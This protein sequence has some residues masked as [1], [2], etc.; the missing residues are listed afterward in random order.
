MLVVSYQMGKVASS[1]LTESIPGCIQIHCLDGEE[2]IKYFSSR[3]TGSVSGRLWQ[4]YKWKLTA[5][6]LRNKIKKEM[7]SGGVVKLL[8]GVRE[9][10]ARNVSGFFQSLTFRE[11][12]DSVREL[13]DKYYAFCPHLASSYW[14]ENELQKHFGIDVYSY[15]FDK[16]LGFSII[17][18]GGVEVFLYQYE[19][20]GGLE[21]DLCRFIGSNDFSLKKINEGSKK[22]SN[23]AYKSFLSE[24]NPSNQYLEFLYSTKYMRH[25]YSD[26]N[27]REYKR[28]WGG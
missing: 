8:V 18:K 14:F 27:I 12:G 21:S 2:P 17:K 15:P 20:I 7:A 1:S 5:S 4:H 3:Y 10:M 13:I 19:K 26:Q 23:D 9:P 25:F 11:K 22:W 6:R 24:F 16:D 28:K